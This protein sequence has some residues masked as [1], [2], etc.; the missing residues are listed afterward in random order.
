MSWL[1]RKNGSTGESDH[2]PRIDFARKALRKPEPD[3]TDNNRRRDRT[4][5]DPRGID[6]DFCYGG[7]NN[8]CA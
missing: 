7:D 2:D 8:P 3:E 1:R 4:T 5:A 6:A